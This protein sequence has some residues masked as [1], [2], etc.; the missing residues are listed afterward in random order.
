ML[1]INLLLLLI[2][3]LYINLINILSNNIILYFIIYSLQIFIQYTINKYK[4]NINKP[5]YL[6]LTYPPLLQT[7]PYPLPLQQL[8]NKLSANIG[9][10][11]NPLFFDN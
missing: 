9:F 8:T 6:N 4:S 1:I 7:T 10:L 11:K 2:N 3:N 5:T